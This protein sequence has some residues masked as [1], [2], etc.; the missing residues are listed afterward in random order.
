MEKADGGGGGVPQEYEFSRVFGPNDDNQ[1]LFAELQVD[2][3]APWAS[4]CGTDLPGRTSSCQ[5]NGSKG[6][7]PEKVRWKW[8]LYACFAGHA[9]GDQ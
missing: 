8:V 2:R 1:R 7:L 3:G 4:I 6:W 9:T 5:A